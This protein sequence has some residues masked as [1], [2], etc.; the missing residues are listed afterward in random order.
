MRAGAHSF[1]SLLRR[2]G[3]SPHALVPRSRWADL[4]YDTNMHSFDCEKPSE[5]SD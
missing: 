3:C 2:P 1:P 4:D 5:A